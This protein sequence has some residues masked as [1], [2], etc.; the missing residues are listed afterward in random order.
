M[1]FPDSGIQRKSYLE[2]SCGPLDLFSRINKIEDFLIQAITPEVGFTSIFTPAN[3]EIALMEISIY[4]ELN[5]WPSSKQ[6]S[7]KP[8]ASSGAVD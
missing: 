3:R 7:P 5:P 4:L 2:N 6:V 1:R 8:T